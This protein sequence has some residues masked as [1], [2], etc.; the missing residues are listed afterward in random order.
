MTMHNCKLEAKFFGPFQILH[1]VGKWAYKLELSRK[2][3]IYNVF[4]VSLL[5]Q[6]TTRKDLVDKKVRQIEFDAGDNSREYKLEVIWDSAVYAK[7]LKSGHLPG[8]Y[9]LVLWKGY[10]EEE[11]TWKPVLAV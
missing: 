5:E 3:R 4:H 7:E 9:Y 6:D 2:W 1:P 8:L 11:N 10:P